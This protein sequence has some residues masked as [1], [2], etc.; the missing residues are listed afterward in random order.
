VRPATVGVVLRWSTSAGGRG[1]RGPQDPRFLREIEARHGLTIFALDWRSITDDGEVTTFDLRDEKLH[2][3]SLGQ[4]DLIH[5]AALG[6]PPS[7]P[8][9][10]REKWSHLRSRLAIV[11]RFGVRCVNPA[12]TLSYGVEKAY[13]LALRDAGIPVVPTRVVAVESG[14]SGVL[15][16][17][18]GPQEHVVKPLAGE[19]GRGVFRL[20]ELDDERFC[21]LARHGDA[22]LV[23]P[24]VPEIDEGERSLVFFRGRLSHA[25]L[26]VPERGGF[27]ANGPHVGALV[28]SYSPTRQEIAF[29]RDAIA[30]FP[31]PVDVCRV[32]C[33]KTAHGLVLMELEVVD[34]GM[35]VSRSH[36]LAN[37]IG[38]LYREILECLD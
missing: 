1:L 3:R 26:K 17:R 9:P 10:L 24:L 13:L 2:V 6:A 31:R 7:G 34:P 33:V 11:E 14:L 18:S 28:R 38:A 29:A 35:Y 25:V 4:L 5:F 15:A 12:E 23:Q 27:L 22:V 16:A 8:E 37:R 20:S 21:E 30:A 19:C 32:D 36:E